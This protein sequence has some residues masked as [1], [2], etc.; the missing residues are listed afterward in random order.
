[1]IIGFLGKGGSGKSTLATH[2]TRLLH[3]LGNTV[4]AIDADYNMDLTHN[5]DAPE[6]MNFL[7]DTACADI[8]LFFNDIHKTTYR[9]IVLEHDGSQK[10]T[11]NPLD[12]FTEKY[13]TE[14]KPGLRL[15]AVGPQTMRVLTGQTCSHGLG[16]SLKAFLPLLDLHKHEAVVVDEKAGAD[17]V[18]T[19]VPTG[20]NLA[21]I[22]VEP[23]VYG[24]KAAKQI[25]GYLDH[26]S[27]QYGFVINK[28]KADTDIADVSKQLNGSVI[29]H[30]PFVESVDDQYIQPIIDFAQKCIEEKGDTRLEL[31]KAKFKFNKEY[32]G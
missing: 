29:A 20:F 8:K 30:I 24:I 21:L 10:F 9:D 5:L 19:G 25:A 14:L 28:I 27:V 15:M 11:L 26:Y 1:M 22:V 18:G 4:L 12:T 32:N 31:S 23:T 3:K 13:S 2:T 16:G 17:S 7:G 6:K